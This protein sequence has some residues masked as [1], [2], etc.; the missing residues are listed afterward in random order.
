MIPLPEWSWFLGF[1]FGTVIGSFLNVVIYRVPRGLSLSKPA[2][3]FCPKCKHPLKTA[4]LVPLVSYLVL[5]RKCRY[6]HEPVSARY[7]AVEFLTGVVWAGIWWQYLLV[8]QEPAKMLAYAAAA[9]CL[10]AIIFIDWELYIIPDQINAVLWLIGM[11][12]SGWLIYQ[13]SPGA[14]TWGMPSGVAGWIVGVGL[15]WGIAFLGLVA[16]R[17]D[18]MGHGDIKMARGIGAVL[19]PALTV[20]SVGLAVV[21]GAVLG[22]VQ[23]LLRGKPT[24]PE[25][26][27]SEEEGEEMPPETIGSLVR[28]GLGY[29][30]LIDVI[31][32]LF[33]KVYKAWFGEDPYAIEEDLE[34][35]EVERTMIPF[36]P[37]LALG[38]IIA[39]VFHGPIFE[40]FEAYQQWAGMR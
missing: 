39:A 5:G 38:A 32:L 26:N 28:C 23:I 3:S 12:Y 37:Y 13:N 25:G 19:F 4:D 35:F 1:W 15:I 20:M 29:L 16:F 18:A 36:G 2:N 21:V 7:F 14:W 10:I 24:E 11:L 8:Q 33:P 31:G 6:C 40:W 27:E 34:T 17:K 22:V 30:L 9:S